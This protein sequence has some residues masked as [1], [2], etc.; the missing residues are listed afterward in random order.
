MIKITLAFL[1]LLFSQILN[2]QTNRCETIKRAIDFVLDHEAEL[3]T[4]VDFSRLLISKERL[5][6]QSHYI[7]ETFID[8]SYWRQKDYYV[9]EDDFEKSVFNMK[10]LIGDSLCD[11]QR[12][13]ENWTHSIWFS[14]IIFG[15]VEIM[16]NDFSLDEANGFGPNGNFK[17]YILEVRKNHSFKIIERV[18]GSY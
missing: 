1:V 7:I 4:T 3:D 11:F 10:T 16:I 13:D 14:D 5:I 15:V 12:T 18:I 17:K 9:S 8:S 6:N 2:G